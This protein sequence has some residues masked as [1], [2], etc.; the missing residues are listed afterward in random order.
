[1]GKAFFAVVLIAAAFAGGLATNGPALAR[2]QALTQGSPPKRANPPTPILDS[3]PDA[4]SAEIPS[5]APSSLA[6]GDLHAPELPPVRRPTPAK[7]DAA[8][9][10]ANRQTTTLDESEAPAPLD[11]ESLDIARAEPAPAP[12]RVED[13]PARSLAEVPA[14]EGWDNLRRRMKTLGVARYW[15]E[16]EP[17]GPCRFRCLIPTAGGRAVSQHFEA[18]AND[19]LH[20]ADAALRRV[21]LWKSTEQP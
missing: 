18:E 6:L 17:E 3:E 19:D 21:A 2:L 16:G 8:L 5:A 14:N 10:Q 11:P 15:I 9:T 12:S 4:P 20:A 1:M 13:T 7:T